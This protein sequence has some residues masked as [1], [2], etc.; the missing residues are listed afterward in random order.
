MGPVSNTTSTLSVINYFS[1]Q[2]VIWVSGTRVIVYKLRSL[3]A[4]RIS[5][6][7]LRRRS[8]ELWIL[9]FVSKG[10]ALLCRQKDEL[11]LLKKVPHSL[12]GLE[13]LITFVC[14]WLF[15]LFYYRLPERISSLGASPYHVTFFASLAL[16]SF[17]LINNE[18]QVHWPSSRCDGKWRRSLIAKSKSADL[19][20][21][22]RRDN[23]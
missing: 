17:V 14:L 9:S 5:Q 15:L 2:T 18:S 23:S 21:S 13:P 4:Y 3:A 12:V 10:F 1:K 20:W 11:K 6:R 7:R 16:N 19:C 8:R 22:A